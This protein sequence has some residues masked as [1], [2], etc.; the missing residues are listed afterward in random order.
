M[1]SPD[2]VLCYI[3]RAMAILSRKWKFWNLLVRRRRPLWFQWRPLC[4]LWFWKFWEK[5]IK[6]LENFQTSKIV[7]NFHKLQIIISKVGGKFWR[8]E[9]YIWEKKIFCVCEEKKNKEEEKVKKFENDNQWSRQPRTP[10]I[11]KGNNPL[12]LAWFKWGSQ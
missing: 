12:S 1:I 2:Y 8:W 10:G 5:K 7:E 6:I 9:G 11:V 3:P 4:C